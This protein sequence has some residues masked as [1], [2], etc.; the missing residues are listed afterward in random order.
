[1]NVPLAELETMHSGLVKAFRK[2]NY[3][4]I[5]PLV[6]AMFTFPNLHANTL[7][8]DALAHIARL[9][10][11][12]DLSA[13]HD[14]F[15]KILN[16]H[17]SASPLCPMEDPVEDAFIGNVA[18]KFGNF[19]V[20]RGIEESGDF[21]LERA[22][23]PIPDEIPGPLEQTIKELRAL[24]TISDGVASR[25]HLPRYFPGGGQRG[26]RFV[27]PRWRDVNEHV[28]AL[29]FTQKDLQELGLDEGLLQPFLFQDDFRAELRRE[30]LGH[31]HLDRYPLCKI[32]DKFVLVAP[33]L[34]VPC[35]VRFFLERLN[36][37][38]FLGFFGMLLHPDQVNEWF[39]TL[40]NGL[41]FTPLDIALPPPPQKMPMIYQTV[42]RFD[43]G[44]FAHV[45]LID[46]NIEANI[47]DYHGFDEFTQTEEDVFAEH[48]E[49]CAKILRSQPDFSGGMT[50]VTR[51][52]VGGRGLVVKLQQLGRDWAVHFASLSDW[53]T[54]AR[55]EDMSALRLWRMW[56]HLQRAKLHGLEVINNNGLLN[57]FAAWRDSD[58]RFIRREMPLSS[59]HKCLL[60]EID[61]VRKVRDEIS[62]A[63]DQHSYPSHDNTRWLHLQRR[64]A[65]AHY[66]EDKTAPMYVAEDEMKSGVLLGVIRRTQNWWV[67]CK[68]RGQNSEQ[69]SVVFKLWDCLLNWMNRATPVIERLIGPSLPTNSIWVELE[70][71]DLE[72]WADQDISPVCTQNIFPF[73]GV[74]TEHQAIL[75]RLPGAYRKE[76]QMPENS[77]E[78]K[79]VS[80][81]IAGLEQLIGTKL[82]AEMRLRLLDEIFPSLDARFFHVIKT[83]NL[84]HI[85]SNDGGSRRTFIPEEEH[86]Q[87]LIGLAG[88]IGE[89][90]ADGRIRGTPSCLDYLK[91]AA[92]KL[93]EQIEFSL[94]RFERR[95]VINACLN[96][97]AALE[98]DGE[99]WNM[100][101]RSQL[102]LHNDENE[103]LQV[104]E[105]RRG[106]RD[107]AILTNRLLIE[108]AMYACNE[109]S[110]PLTRSDHLELLAHMH[111][112]VSTANHRDAISEGFMKPEVRVFPNGEL[113]VDDHFYVSVMLPYIRAKFADSFHAWAKHY[114]KWFSGYES[115][116]SN[117]G[118]KL[119]DRLEQPFLKE[120]GITIDQLVS[121]PRHFGRIALQRKKL[122]L[123]FDDRSL[124][125]TLITEYSVSEATLDRYLGRFSLFPRSSWNKDLPAGVKE[126]DVFPWRFRRR[127]SLLMRPLIQL[128]C[129]PTKQWAIF[130][131]ALEASAM[132]LLGNLAES[133]FP[134]EH[135]QSQEM[136]AF[137][138][139]QA[140][141]QGHSFNEE[142]SDVF[143]KYGFS[144]ASEVLM[145]K[146]GVPESL[147]DL[148]DVDVLAWRT[149]ISAVFV[150]ECKHL[151]DATSVR[152]V[153]DRLKEYRGEL[154]DSLGK[155]LRR[156]NW[157]KQNQEKLR[158]YVKD[159][160]PRFEIKSLLVTS[161]LVPMQFFSDSPLK[162]HDVVPIDSLPQY[163]KQNI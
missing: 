130:P 40:H 3:N 35:A 106:K 86:A 7:R 139:D 66:T 116:S 135:F 97:L 76:F 8:L 133:A 17:F 41:G 147:G 21:W 90:P 96:A 43:I 99:H 72:Q 60:L 156:V 144:V 82:S 126:H 52:G 163:F 132:Y 80:A 129:G 64:T 162:P 151:R 107:A 22:L 26:K 131:P 115:E 141:R 25:L 145:K 63:Y 98:R 51:G 105:Q 44:K 112:L 69:R 127:L 46:G 137:C 101:A 39:G 36:A 110:R 20:F 93:W 143:K 119:L 70:V 28:D 94:R 54:L 49:Q 57:L 12:G 2:Y 53:Q 30:R 67:A 62:Q 138:G 83:D 68:T 160:P 24:L 84:S 111:N 122:V 65:K 13:N 11:T 55:S 161:D 38:G 128:N 149:D 47:D 27:V 121:I 4:S 56:Q 109:G 19:R 61:F 95:S 134:A 75:I 123:E 124:R 48:M 33:H 29:C 79:L 155:H 103:V 18:T 50:L 91:A 140:N 157:L 125:E 117:A 5:G 85:L 89:I 142:V 37:T 58:W 77:A 71:L 154:G 1:M 150:I 88:L 16:R 158:S 6:A 92:D 104:A 78:V 14:A 120:F 45:V 15:A 73:G 100:T 87:S 59:P 114:E 23:R 159:L 31:T 81:V 34:V 108:T 102:A 152:D 136:R 113:D 146:I 42:M 118:S 148:G 9:N 10:C 32:N 153:V 74:N